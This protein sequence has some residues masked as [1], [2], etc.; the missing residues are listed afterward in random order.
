M[1]KNDTPDYA[2]LERTYHE[3]GRLAIM[4]ILCAAEKGLAFPELR[5][6]CALTDGNLNRHLK[7]L[8]EARAVQVDKS[9]VGL[10]P[11]TLI[12]VTRRGLDEFQEYLRALEEALKTARKAVAQERGGGWAALAR[13]KD[14]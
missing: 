4:S 6:A 13:K 10:K 1:K 7:V 2:A 3:P 11:R 12:R 8:E 9:F 5:D 14:A